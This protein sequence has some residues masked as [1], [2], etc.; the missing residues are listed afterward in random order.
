MTQTYGLD[1]SSPNNNNNATNS[2]L[3]EPQDRRAVIKKAKEVARARCKVD[4]MNNML[5]NGIGFNDM[6][7]FYK[8]L[9]D[10]KTNN[11]SKNKSDEKVAKKVKETLTEKLTDAKGTVRKRMREMTNLRRKLTDKH[12]NKTWIQNLFKKGRRME[13]T[14]V[15]ETS[16]KNQKKIN[17]ILMKKQQRMKKNEFP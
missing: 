16:L 6:T 15:K 11:G 12:G 9:E 10:Q 8:R 17:Q 4:L 2:E 13:E 1:K 14:I 5:T 7:K 3:T